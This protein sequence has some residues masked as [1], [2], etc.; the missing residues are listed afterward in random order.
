M[1]SV[2]ERGSAA[3]DKFS[4]LKHLNKIY[5]NENHYL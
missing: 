3:E 4:S 1:G 2:Q 5:E